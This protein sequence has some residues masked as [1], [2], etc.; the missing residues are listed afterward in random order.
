MQH[1][2]LDAVRCLWVQHH[3]ALDTMAACAGVR[4]GAFDLDD[5]TN[6]SDVHTEL[7]AQAPDSG[8]ALANDPT[9]A[10]G[11]D[12]ELELV[13]R[14]PPVCAPTILCVVGGAQA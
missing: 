4:A 1:F 2:S 3:H 12:W 14:R 8:T 9:H 13:A 11:G 10:L 7:R 6:H 5:V